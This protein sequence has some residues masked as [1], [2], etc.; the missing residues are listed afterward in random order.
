MIQVGDQLTAEFV[1]N[2]GPVMGPIISKLQETKIWQFIDDAKSQ[3]TG[4][5]FYGGE[6]DMVPTTGDKEN[7]KN[8]FWVR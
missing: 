3:G 4:E 2:E 7:T 5:L 8:G 1:D 6:R